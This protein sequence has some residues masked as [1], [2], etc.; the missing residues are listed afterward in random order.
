MVASRS[1]IVG[2]LTVK[3]AFGI[4]TGHVVHGHSRSSFDTG[5]NGCGVDR[6]AAPTTDTDDTD[7]LRVNILLHGEEV[8]RCAEILG[9]DVR[10]SNIARL[11]AA[12]AGVG[13]VEGNR[14]E[15]KLRHFLRI[16]A[17]GLLLY[18]TER[19]ADGNSGQLALRTLRRVHICRQRDAVAVM[20]GHFFMV[21]LAAFR[22]HLVPFLC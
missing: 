15:A 2:I 14:Q 1:L 20:K 22:E 9:V 8:Y 19:P 16:Q 21:H 3:V 18:R 5:V 13:R 17:G 11:T 10:R 7:A 6:H 12:L 4:H